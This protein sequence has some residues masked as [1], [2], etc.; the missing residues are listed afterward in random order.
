MRQRSMLAF[1]SCLAICAAACAKNPGD[2]KPHAKVGQAAPSS[3]TATAPAAEKIALTPE[4]SSIGF[5]GSKVTGSHTG[6]FTAFSGTVALA[7]S[8]MAASGVSLDIDLNSTWSDSEKLTG[9]LKSPDFFDTATHP[10]ATFASTKVEPA[11]AGGPNYTVTGNLDLHGVTK[12]ISFPAT[13]EATPQEVIVNA[14]F[15]INR[16]DF[17]IVYPGKPDDLIRDEVVLKI[18]VKAPRKV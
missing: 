2:D 18:A 8:G 3:Q 17:N 13:I 7:P 10:K 4:N 1:V 16:K 11:A 14:E 9:H 12:S 6:G 5:V 15:A